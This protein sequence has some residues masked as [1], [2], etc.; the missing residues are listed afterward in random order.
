MKFKCLMVGSIAAITVF[1][2][3]KEEISV[4]NQKKI[5]KP[6][7]EEISVTNQKKIDKPNKKVKIDKADLMSPEAGGSA[8]VRYGDVPIPP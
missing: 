5:D 4:D 3:Q 2:C 8:T 7:K 6:N 1:A